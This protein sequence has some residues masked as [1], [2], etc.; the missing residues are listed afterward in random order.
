MNEKETALKSILAGTCNQPHKYLGM[1]DMGAGKKLIRIA[2]IEAKSAFIC[3]FEKGE[4]L[5][6]MQESSIK[7]I[8]EGQ[9]EL[10]EWPL[11]RVHLTYE[12]GQVYDYIDPYQ[13]LPQITEDELYL[14]NK[15]D[16]RRAYEKMGSHKMVVRGVE[17]TL[18]AVWA[19]T[20]QRVSVVGS[21]NFWNGLQHP[22]RSLGSSGVWELFI[23]GVT[24]GALYKYEIYTQ[25]NTLRLKSD[26][27]GV[28]FQLRPDTASIVFD[29]KYEWQAGQ[30]PPDTE[31]ANSYEKPM[32]IYEVHAGSWRRHDDWSW[33]NYR[34]MADQ[35][36]PY[37]KEM[38]YTHVELMPIMEH[39]F[40]GS[41]GY[42]VSGYFAATSRFGNPDDLRCFIDRAHSAGIGVILDWV[43]AHFPKDDFALARFDG[44]A[45][46]EHEDPRLGEHPD[47]GTYIFNFGRNEVKNFLISNALYWLR[48]FRADGLRIDAVASMLFLDYSRSTGE[49]IPNRYGGNENLEAIEFMKHLNSVISGEFPNALII[50]EESTAFGGVTKAVEKDGLGF[51]YKWNMGWMNDFLRYMSKDP[52]YRKYH[53][54]D[55]TFS[56][57]YHYSEKFIL[58]ISHDEVVHGKRSLLNKMPGDDWQKFANYKLLM[59]IMMLH[60][61][62]KLNFMGNELAP[63][64]EWNETQGV[65]WHLMQWMPHSAAYHYIKN[66]NHLYLTEAAL[67]EMDYDPK[68][69]TWIDADNAS[70]SLISFV[71][72][73]KSGKG[74]LL[75]VANFLPDAHYDFRQGV[76]EAGTYSEIFNS[77][78]AE[79]NGSGVVENTRHAT[80]P[81]AAHNQ[82]NSLMIGIPPLGFIVLKK[83]S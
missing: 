38:G 60:P 78:L 74:H 56:M 58:A 39:P 35:L 54:N 83:E 53:H 11:Y 30:F 28:Y 22:M 66:L 5:H 50:A 76:L 29:S 47:W 81:I 26:P 17:G 46:Y 64:N 44:T 48:E 14:F 13:F 36:I 80:E 55:L 59:G 82:P 61:G 79:Y 77:D 43:P 57:L 40:D 4:E 3:F 37:L 33:M 41:W 21:F 18:F 70:D 27:Y 8:W 32:N 72:R 24:D 1:H 51:T 15:G 45:L 69:F 25:F 19:P 52:I 67:W 68:G 75:I 71:R 49:W 20:A 9:F 6:A 16:Y 10:D 2:S 65:E 34:E 12:D 7:G 23:P 62:K 31:S 42:Q 63:W 73:D